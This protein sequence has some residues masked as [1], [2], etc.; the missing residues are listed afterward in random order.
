MEYIKI[1]G[2]QR[3]GTNY[4]KAL[5]E[6]NFEVRVLQNICGSKHSVITD[7]KT[8]K[9]QVKTDLSD[10]TIKWLDDNFWSLKKLCIYKPFNEWEESYNR[11]K[12]LKKQTTPLTKELQLTYS[13]ILRHWSTH[14][15][16]MINYNEIIKDYTRFLYKTM[17]RYKLVS[18]KGFFKD[19]DSY[20]AAGGDL[21]YTNNLT[22]IKMKKK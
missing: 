12:Q 17:D 3:S 16:A 6:K 21:F 4:L 8:N 1:Y 20:M 18:K 13:K 11:Y 15:D 10:K 9:S 22:D 7:G 5:L 14:C 2:L 19:I